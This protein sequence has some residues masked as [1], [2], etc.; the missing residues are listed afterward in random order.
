MTTSQELK[1]IPKDE[2]E[3]LKTPTHKRPADL[4]AGSYE[5]NNQETFSPAIGDRVAAPKAANKLNEPRMKGKK[6]N[7]IEPP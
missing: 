3:H 5:M 1:L 6:G 4:T 7:K 2:L